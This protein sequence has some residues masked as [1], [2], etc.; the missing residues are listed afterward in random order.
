MFILKKKISFL[1]VLFFIK[2]FALFAQENQVNIGLETGPNYSSVG[3]SSSGSKP[4]VNFSIAPTIQFI[5]SDM[6]SMRAAFGIERKGLVTIY[7]ARDTTGAKIRNIKEKTNYDYFVL[8][9]MERATFG[10]DSK[11]RGFFNGGL[12]G[13]YL[14]RES[15]IVENNPPIVRTENFKR[16]DFGFLLGG[17]A[18]TS[19]GDDW[20][21]SIEMRY[22]HGLTPIEKIH[23]SERYT[24]HSFNFLFGIAYRFFEM[25]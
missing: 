2:F 25:D 6:I 18:E 19:L 1:I 13:G 10:E 15:H 11:V 5:F 3:R 21:L 14:I 23:F 17:G 16:L 12:F 7:T 9:I 22:C 4:A 8:P 24:T 20:I